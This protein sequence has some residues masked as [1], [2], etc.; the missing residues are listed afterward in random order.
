MD[1]FNILSIQ[2]CYHGMRIQSGGYKY[3]FFVT[4]FLK[5]K[6]SALGKVKKALFFNFEYYDLLMVREMCLTL[7]SPDPFWRDN[8]F[9]AN[10]GGELRVAKIRG[11]AI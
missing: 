9:S 11:I 4:L 10:F 2:F 3:I 7:W 8:A 6:I 1:S 5:I